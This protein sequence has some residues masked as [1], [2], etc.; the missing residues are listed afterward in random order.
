MTKLTQ[1]DIE[2][3]TLAGMLKNPITEEVKQAIV[4]VLLKLNNPTYFAKFVK[5]HPIEYHGF[6]SSKTIN[7]ILIAISN[8]LTLLKTEN[9]PKK[10]LQS[11]QTEF[12]WAF[13]N[14]PKYSAVNL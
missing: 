14:L 7:P 3:F 1:F 8:M 13:N 11:L 12:A 10:L 5:K 2:F 9:N 6:I 4:R